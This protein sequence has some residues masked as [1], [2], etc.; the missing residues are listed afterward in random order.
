M[1]Q[2][3]GSIYEEGPYGVI[4]SGALRD[5]RAVKRT[6]ALNTVEECDAAGERSD[7][8]MIGDTATTLSGSM[9]KRGRYERAVAGAAIATLH[10]SLAV[11]SAGRYVIAIEADV[12]VGKNLTLAAGA[13]SLFTIE[14]DDA[15][16]VAPST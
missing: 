3:L 13:D 15:E 12:I 11:D 9:L 6:T 7:G 1:A 14:L 8:I 4:A 10:N 5:G 2:Q 16:R